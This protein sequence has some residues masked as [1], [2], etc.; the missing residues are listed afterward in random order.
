MSRRFRDVFPGLC[1]AEGDKIRGHTRREGPCFLRAVPFLAATCLLALLPSSP[2]LAVDRSSGWPTY[3]FDYANTR[4]VDIDDINRSNVAH[5]KPVWRYVLG[6]HERVETTPV[7]VGETMFVTTGTG[8]N[9]IALDAAT[10]RE[11]WRYRPAIG[12]MAACCGLLNRG[13]AVS[14][15]R[16][17]FATMDGRL[18]ALDAGSGKRVWDVKIGDAGY[19]FSETMAPL[20]WDGL[21]F[22]GSSGSDYGLRGSLSAYRAADGK[23]VWRW[24]AVSRGWEG[25]YVGAVHG[26]S[27][28]RNLEQEKR[29][30]G[31]FADAWS[32][33][34][35]AIWM[36]PALDAKR[37]TLY[38]TTSNPWPVFHGSSRPGDNLYTDC[39]VALNVR[40]GKMR[41]YYQE[42]PHDVWEYEPSSPPVLFDARTPRGDLPVVGQAGKTLWFYIVDRNDGAFVRI[43]QSLAPNSNVYDD[44]PNGEPN[45]PLPLRGSLGPISFDS[46]R[47]RA[48]I[49]VIDRP[50]SPRSETRWRD[51]LAAVDVDSGKVV[52]K[53][54]LGKMHDG[55]RG[56]P[57]IAGSLSTPGL[58]FVAEPFGAFYAL[59]AD[60]GAIAWQH[61]LGAGAFADEDSNLFV[62]FAH[63]VR[64][65]LLP[66]KRWAFHEDAPMA[67]SAGVDSNPIAYEAG[68][69]EFVA[70]GFDAQPDLAAGGAMVEAFSL[71]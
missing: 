31:T 67:A 17:F 23:L 64:D 16:L 43:S 41:W 49:A 7:V 21:V 70:I 44:P 38:L 22:I 6:P 66:A 18:F 35:G 37:E 20:T 4:H 33:G 15:N 52:W 50:D 55:I 29:D 26:M 39:I 28:H 1:L 34:G 25:D 47:H 13:V 12:P 45:A 9:V 8:N 53:E 40:T 54:F 3:G 65:W 2:S 60:S 62:K 5:L 68:G 56:D 24:Y 61:A 51:V 57:L 10:G 48:F 19:G 11:K 36:T 46:S 30:A 32:H 71:R 63:R 14:G 42:T 58:V 69:R 59:N 27:L